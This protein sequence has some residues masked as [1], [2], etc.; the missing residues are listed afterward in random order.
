MLARQSPPERCMIKLL[1]T[2]RTLHNMQNGVL[3]I[4]Q[5]GSESVSAL[6][7]SDSR[8]EAAAAAEE[9]EGAQPRREKG[10]VNIRRGSL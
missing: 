2:Q 4:S 9:H 7:I 10:A 1:L 3:D 6:G 8:Q 5:R